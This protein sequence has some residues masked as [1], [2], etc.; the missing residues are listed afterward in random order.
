MLPSLG[1]VIVKYRTASLTLERLRA[2]APDLAN[3]PERGIVVDNSFR[4]WIG[5][6]AP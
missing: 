5:R 4:R 1:I 3:F 2:L 6:S